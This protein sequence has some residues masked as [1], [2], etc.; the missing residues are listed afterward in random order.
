MIL[1]FVEVWLLL[2]VAFAFG[3]AAGALG[4]ELLA[5]TPLAS[6]QTTLAVALGRIADRVRER[7]GIDPVWREYQH[8]VDFGHPQPEGPVADLIEPPIPRR[9]QPVEP[10]TEPP[11]AD[12]GDGDREPAPP[13]PA[14]TR[15]VGQE[16]TPEPESGDTGPVPMRPAAL[17]EPRKGV[18]DNLQRIRG[19]GEKN[20]HV[21]NALGIY[22]FGQIAAW[23]PAEILWISEHISFPERIERDDWIGQAVI[24]AAGGDTGITKS[25]ERRREHRNELFLS[26]EDAEEPV[27]D[28]D[29][30]LEEAED[31]ADADGESAEH[32]PTE[33][34][35]AEVEAETTEAMDEA[36]EA[37]TGPDPSETAEPPH[38]EAPDDPNG[39]VL[40]DDSAGEEDVGEGDDGGEARNAEAGDEPPADDDDTRST[41]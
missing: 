3:C 26:D 40:P 21:L 12:D 9:T 1:H 28:G 38:D 20:E 24:L 2:F 13:R 36:D 16:A 6:A 19:I 15:A 22:H 23:T 33:P 7:F 32:E 35:E 14:P 5:Q 17:L 4:Y 25:D 31:E 29:E 39:E 10:P 41:D 8:A 27:D 30:H 37:S 11:P 34:A 18:P